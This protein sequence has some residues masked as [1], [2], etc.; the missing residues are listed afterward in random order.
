MISKYKWEIALVIIGLA[1]TV[2][3]RDYAVT[4][5]L[6][7]GYE[8]GIGGEFLILPLIAVW[9]AAVKADWSVE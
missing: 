4:R 7:M 6:S 2:I 9:Y 8:P 1:L 5:R 3:A